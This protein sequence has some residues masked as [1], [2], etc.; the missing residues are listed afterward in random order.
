[1]KGW[2]CKLSDVGPSKLRI[3]YSSGED[4]MEVITESVVASKI[5]PCGMVAELLHYESELVRMDSIYHSFKLLV[6]IE[7]YKMPITVAVGGDSYN[8]VATAHMQAKIAMH[9]ITQ[10]RRPCK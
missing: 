7:V 4:I 5:M 9:C 1:M 8:S 3:A 2:I 10:Y 6:G